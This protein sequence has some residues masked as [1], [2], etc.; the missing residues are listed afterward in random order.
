MATAD[1]RCAHH[2]ASV[3]ARSV[4]KVFGRTGTAEEG[5]RGVSAFLVPADLK[6]ISHKLAED[7]RGLPSVTR[8]ARDYYGD[9]DTLQAHIGKWRRD[10]LL[11]ALWELGVAAEAVNQPGECWDDEQVSF[12]QLLM[13]D[14]EGY[15]R[16]GLP[17]NLSVPATAELRGNQNRTPRVL[18]SEAPLTGI[19]VV[20]FGSFTA[21]PHASIVLSD[22]GADVIKVEPLTG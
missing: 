8:E 14:A 19:R 5:A 16:V 12:N 10:E 17:F 21:G 3:P 2:S 15:R 11:S 6:G 1:Y 4:T 18:G 7:P 20:D 22:L 13:R 9:K